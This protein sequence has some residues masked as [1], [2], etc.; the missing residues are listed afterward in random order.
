MKTQVGDEGYCAPFAP[1]DGSGIVAKGKTKKPKSGAKSSKARA[2]SKVGAKADAKPGAKSP[3]RKSGAQPGS[4]AAGRTDQPAKSGT[5]K[6]TNGSSQRGKPAALTKGASAAQLSD[7]LLLSQ[8][9]AAA[10]TKPRSHLPAGTGGGKCWLRQADPT[11]PASEVGK[12]QHAVGVV[13]GAD[14]SSTAIKCKSKEAVA[15]PQAIGGPSQNPWTGDG[16]LSTVLCAARL[17]SGSRAAAPPRIAPRLQRP[18]GP[19]AVRGPA[20]PPPLPPMAAEAAGV[21]QSCLKL[22]KLQAR[23]SNDSNERQRQSSAQ[24]TQ[25]AHPSLSHDHRQQPISSSSVPERYAGSVTALRWDMSKAEQPDL[26]KLVT[27]AAELI[28][29]ALRL[30]QAMS[31]RQVLPHPKTA[32]QK[33]LVGG[34]DSLLAHRK[35]TK[36]TSLLAAEPPPPPPALPPPSM[37]LATQQITPGADGGGG[38]R[39]KARQLESEAVEPT[40][41]EAAVRIQSALRARSRS[42]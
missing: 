36:P 28:Q 3:L 41:E 37:I 1:I 23:Q 18:P 5:P 25:E 13:V 29:S 33:Q 22:K 12:G 31:R 2:D 4:S 20:A 16:A 39:V 34:L 40:E 10:T 19:A 32:E 42:S 30:K 35:S 24:P 6:R 7:S 38:L 9:R 11:K 15:T 8:R 14:G 27:E 17:A 21:I 26:G